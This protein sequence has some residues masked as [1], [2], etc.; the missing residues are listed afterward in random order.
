MSVSTRGNRNHRRSGQF[1]R[2]ATSP[3][4]AGDVRPPES[5]RSA[6]AVFYFGVL[7]WFSLQLFLV[8]RT[9]FTRPIP[10]IPDDAYTYLFEG[11]L[12][13]L[14]SSSDPPA[15][16]DIRAQASLSTSDPRVLWEQ[17]R[18]DARFVTPTYFFWGFV[19]S[20]IH[21]LGV[22]W[23]QTWIIATLLG[24]IL[25]G[26]GTAVF[27]RSLFAPIPAG[28][29]MC[30]VVCQPFPVH[31]LHY[32]IPWNICLGIALGVWGLQIRAGGYSLSAMLFGTVALLLSHP[33][34]LMLTA[35]TVA[36]AVG[37]GGRPQT[38]IQWICLFAVAAVTF[39]S[40]LLQCV[41][42]V[43]GNY[44]EVRPEG[45]TFLGGLLA[46]LKEAW[47]GCRAWLGVAWPLLPMAAWG[48]RDYSGSRRR[49]WAIVIPVV[50]L[51]L[52]SLLYQ[53][54]RYPS[55]LFRRF[56]PPLAFVITGLAGIGIVQLFGKCRGLRRE[57]GAVDDR[58]QRRRFGVRL[59]GSVAAF[60]FVLLVPIAGGFAVMNQKSFE[61]RHREDFDLRN[62]QVQKLLAVSEPGDRVYYQDEIVL[63]F[64]LS[65]GA[66]SRG[67]VY[68]PP[69]KHLPDAATLLRSNDP[70]FGVVLHPVHARYYTENLPALRPGKYPLTIS[71]PVRPISSLRVLIDGP[72]SQIAIRAV[73]ISSEG[74]RGSE[75]KQQAAIAAHRPTWVTIDVNNPTGDRTVELQIDDS[76][77]EARLLGLRT[78]DGPLAWPWS[79]GLVISSQRFDEGGNVD[80]SFDPQLLVPEP[81]RDLKIEVLDD[82]GS[83]LL[84]SLNRN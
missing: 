72:Q 59:A 76:R 18:A 20:S 48:L 64:Y 70:R 56:L 50:A 42:D 19:Y 28:I 57:F 82:Q 1:A 4:P 65:R 25:L 6:T 38:K 10:P 43:G 2:F 12:W 51:L 81:L 79:E 53:Q 75:V 29:A 8:G 36:L 84:L 5:S 27:L 71:S 22:T 60:A 34:G 66:M 40:W 17:Q 33:M 24:T 58:I 45:F 26:I 67:C 55:D 21:S 41:F 78:G 49:I 32:V 23:E 13:D 3:E 31:G 47:A 44:N 73:S 77:A 68:Y 39:S 52:L 61:L 35:V 11:V 46:N 62:P 63:P 16:A 30:L 9:I 54:P 80:W 83:S 7:V 14:R 37:L 69:L 15:M 74:V